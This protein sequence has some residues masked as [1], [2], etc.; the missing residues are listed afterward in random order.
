MGVGVSG[1]RLA[2]AVASTGQL[3]VVSGVALDTLMVRRLQL[4]D[5][6]G[7]IRRALARFPDPSV[8]E[9]IVERYFVEGG[10]DPGAP[11]RLVPKVTVVPPVEVSKPVPVSVTLVPP[12]VGPLDAPSAPDGLGGC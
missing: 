1:W 2:R 7:D 5:R 4:G 10:I 11:F 12:A 6:G 3:G 8:A 9:R